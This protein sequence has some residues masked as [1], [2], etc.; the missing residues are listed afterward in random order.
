M[1][2]LFQTEQCFKLYLSDNFDDSNKDF[3]VSRAV[4]L[5]EDGI[6]KIVNLN[7]SYA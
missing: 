7:L 1:K 6:L 2:Q 3:E 4:I 5:W